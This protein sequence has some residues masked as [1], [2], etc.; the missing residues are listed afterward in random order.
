MCVSSVMTPT[1]YPRK[2]EDNPIFQTHALATLDEGCGL[3]GGQLWLHI[4]KDIWR[5][6]LALRNAFMF[7]GPVDA[8]TDY[9]PI[10]FHPDESRP[11]TI[12][13]NRVCYREWKPEYAG[14]DEATFW[15]AKEHELR[16]RN[17]QLIDNNMMM[18]PEE[19]FPEY[20]KV[21]YYHVPWI[22]KLLNV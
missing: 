9:Y 19:A 17:R 5:R 22:Y 3:S 16:A 20:F 14:T 6:R 8:F 10:A 7:K 21:L 12:P 15:K 4:Q 2:D 18:G 11:I 13:G 1:I